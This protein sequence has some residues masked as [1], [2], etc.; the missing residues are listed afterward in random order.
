[1]PTTKHLSARLATLMKL[2]L[3][4]IGMTET[5][6][7]MTTLEPASTRLL[8]PSFRTFAEIISCLSIY[9]LVG[10]YLAIQG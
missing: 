3:P 2:V 8:A 5:L 4:V 9:C 1:M 6:T 10:M 7:D